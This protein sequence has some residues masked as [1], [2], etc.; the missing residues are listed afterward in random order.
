MAAPET[1]SAR[2]ARRKLPQGSSSSVGS[3]RKHSVCQFSGSAPLAAIRKHMGT[4]GDSCSRHNRSHTIRCRFRPDTGNSSAAGK[5]FRLPRSS[6]RN[7][8]KA[9]IPCPYRTHTS[10][11]PDRVQDDSSDTSPVFRQPCPKHGKR[12]SFACEPCRLVALP[13]ILHPSR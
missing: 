13:F 5:T 8:G 2:A 4:G 6:I 10:L 7:D 12:T 1:T 11:Y 3:L 9:G